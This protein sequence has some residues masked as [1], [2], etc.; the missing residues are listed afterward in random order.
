MV[1]LATLTPFGGQYELLWGSPVE[2][3]L[4]A[5]L[6]YDMVVMGAHGANRLDNFFL[7]GVA[8]RVV[9]HSKIPVLTVREETTITS[10]KRLLFATDFGKASKQA[11]H[12]CQPL[13]KAGIKIVAVNVIDDWRLQ[14]DQDYAK[15]AADSL[16][17]LCEGQTEQQLIYEGNPIEVLPTIAKEVAADVIVIGLHRHTSM[18]GLFLGSRA[19]ALLRSSSL[20][21]LSVPFVKD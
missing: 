6:R 20:P 17:Y 18:A 4:K 10:I 16:R 15:T 1:M 13:R 9:R 12:W 8:G 11:W 14:N 5:S 21:I 2:A 19:D 7:G 3:I